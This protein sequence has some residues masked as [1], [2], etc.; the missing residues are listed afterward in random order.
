M[1]NCGQ[2]FKK[3]ITLFWLINF[4]AFPIAALHSF[5]ALDAND[6][7][8]SG[9]FTTFPGTDSDSDSHLFLFLC[10]AEDEDDVEAVEDNFKEE[11]NLEVDDD[12]TV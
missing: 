3:N 12:A 8:S 5:I 2:F 7:C 6:S 1:K 4:S 11:D 10:A 9:S